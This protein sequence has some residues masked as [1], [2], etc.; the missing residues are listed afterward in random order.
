MEA[1]VQEEKQ[2][3]DRGNAFFNLER[4]EE[5]ITSY[6][7]AL[8]IKPDFHEAWHNRG[9]ALTGLERYEEAITSYNEAISIESDYHGVWYLRGGALIGLER[10]EEAITSYDK[11]L[12]I[13]P[14]YYEA[15]HNRGVALT[16]LERYEEAITSYNEAIS[17]ESDY[18]GVWYL[19]GG[20]LIG[21][22]RYEEAITSYDKSL[23][24]KPD[25]YEAWYNQGVALGNLG[26]YE[27]AIVSYDKSLAIKPDFHEA[28]NS[29]G[30]ALGNL[31]RY[32][33]AIVSYDKALAIKPDY[34]KAWFDRGFASFN[35]GKYEE[36]I[37]SY[38]EAISIESD[39]YTVWA[40]LGGAL[41]NLGRYEEAIAS[42]NKALAI[43]PDCYEAYFSLGVIL[44]GL[45]RYEEAI[46][47]FDKVIS[48][49][50]NN[51]RVWSERGVALIGLK[52]YE[53]AIASCNKALAIQHDYYEAWYN[54][55][56][57]LGNLGRYEEAIASYDKA[58]AI[59]PD[60]HEAWN[61]RAIAIGNL[62]G[63]E[64]K[65]KAYQPAFQYI[66]A[67]THLEGWGFL[68]HAIGRTHY[69][70]RKQQLNS[71]YSYAS[72]AITSYYTALETLIATTFP[73]LRLETLAD[74][75]SA[76]LLRRNL[77]APSDITTA[78]QV[79]TEALSLWQ[80]LL[81]QQPS[82]AAKKKLYQK[83][84]YLLRTQVD[85]AILQGD[86]R[87]ALA[88]AELHKNQYL[89]WF[90]Y[91]QAQQGRTDSLRLQEI[92]QLQWEKVSWQDPAPLLAPHCAIIYWHLSS[93]TLS[94]F[95]LHPCQP[96]PIVLTASDQ[97]LSTWLEAYDTDNLP[98]VDWHS[99]REILQI[100]AINHHLADINNLILIPH[101]DLH[102]LPLHSLWPEHSTSY[103]PSI[104]TGLN[105]LAK[106][107]PVVTSSLLLIES[108]TYDS[109]PKTGK[110][111]KGL[112]NAEIEAAILGKMFKTASADIIPKG[113]VNTANICAG[114][115][116]PRSFAHF[117]GHAY[118]DPDQPQDSSLILD[119]G[120]E[121]SCTQF[122][123][124]NLLPY[125]LIG[126]S[127][128]ET[129]TTSQIKD[130]EYV[131]LVS[132]CLSRGVNYVLSTLWPV[133]DLPSSMF[134]IYFYSLVGKGYT[135]PAALRRTARWLRKLTH[136]KAATFHADLE[137]WLPPSSTR[138]SITSN[139]RN[140]EKAAI[141][142]PEECPF[143]DHYY[144]AAFTL[145]G[146]AAK[147]R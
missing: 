71:P 121:F 127:A 140:A 64:A 63:Y 76:L 32:E 146:L 142:H 29:R 139:R 65:I 112:V 90:L 105:L 38:N 77:E 102:R 72:K 2:W 104:Q 79:Q 83:Y 18:H 4:Y 49:E 48:V 86:P 141:A 74:L 16:G 44:T 93:Q 13:Q 109:H 98:T 100:E 57:A 137:R 27:E 144:W 25:Y 42:C 103:L 88:I 35:L 78:Y 6:D 66:Q 123:Q 47:S 117:N 58:L 9:V 43:K 11:A 30:N 31:G 37:T 136:Q 60:G 134:V 89:H 68:H 122:H 20:A 56:I 62:H 36:A 135:P 39:D 1:L 26:R 95:I 97:L 124:L 21:L 3:F 45:E 107:A 113:K 61:S 128:C 41:G 12:A 130:D 33:E 59:K 69:E 138:E 92:E 67:T 126:L 15:W 8:A 54:L 131:G 5:A 75:A 84:A 19:R 46:A 50:F 108:P 28:W 7:K 23:A 116:I 133:V 114:M 94:T 73:T 22:E 101:R 119:N 70:A 24:I 143:S 40:N 120:A 82:N 115:V 14:G 106:G 125:Y 91:A 145:S 85:L 53:E 129:G 80:Q 147:A 111:C 52:G 34:Y 99:L 51:Y 55:G 81:T 132:A 10:Y 17:I 87:Q 96:E 110:A 118:H